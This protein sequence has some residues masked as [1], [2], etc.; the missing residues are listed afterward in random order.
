MSNKKIIKDFKGNTVNEKET[1]KQSN[2]IYQNEILEA[3][4]LTSRT[5]ARIIEHESK[6]LDQY[7]N[8]LISPSEMI[9]INQS[10][11]NT[12]NTIIDLENTIISKLRLIYSDNK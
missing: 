2:E 4:V 12:L 9:T 1:I 3:A 11:I 6:R 7:I 5:I 10:I 8:Q